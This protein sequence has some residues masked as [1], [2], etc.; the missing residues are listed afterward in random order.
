MDEPAE[1]LTLNRR[2]SRYRVARK[3]VALH[4][5]GHVPA[6]TVAFAH[7]IDQRRRCRSNGICNP[8]PPFN[9]CMQE[10]FS[11]GLCTKCMSLT[12]K[13]AAQF[14]EVINFPIIGE[15]I[16]ITVFLVDHWLL[17]ALWVNHNKAAMHQRRTRG[18]PAS[19]RISPS[20][21]E[22]ISHTFYC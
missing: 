2:G 9:I 16:G 22:R 21:T 11:I 4:L 7:P 19:L 14:S 5:D 6:P 20:A 12:F 10:Y 8:P 3:T 17:S 18:Y 13:F 15:S 1:L